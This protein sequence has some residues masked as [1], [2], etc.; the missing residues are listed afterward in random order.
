VASGYP[1]YEGGKQ[2]VYLVQQWAVEGA[3]DKS[4]SG[5]GANLT[6]G[7]GISVLYNVPAAKKLVIVSMALS[8]KA[9][10][11]ANADLPHHV[12]AILSI[13]GTEKTRI[14]TD[15]GGHWNFDEPYE[16]AAGQL[17]E[18]D[19]NVEANHAVDI[20]LSVQAYEVPV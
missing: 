15:A 11:Q 10:A 16:G 4:F 14:G 5:T 13:G 12:S 2:R 9:T 19:G 7:M 6:W 8:V 18:F 3:L 20:T 1:D 17:V